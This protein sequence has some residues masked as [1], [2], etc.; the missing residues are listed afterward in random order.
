MEEIL[1]FRLILRNRRLW[2]AGKKVRCL[3]K[4]KLKVFPSIL[5]SCCHNKM[6]YLSSSD[7]QGYE[8]RNYFFSFKYIIS[9]ERE[10]LIYYKICNLAKRVLAVV[11]ICRLF[12][13]LLI[14]VIPK[15]FA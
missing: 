11:F 3:E 14:E 7:W 5:S 1:C 10:K 9:C 2:R 13:V 6:T 15:Q 8:L 4:Y 12:L